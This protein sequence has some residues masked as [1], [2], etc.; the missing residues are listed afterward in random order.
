MS[1]I[2]LTNPP[3]TLVEAVALAQRLRVIADEAEVQLMRYL[4]WLEGRPDLWQ[5]AADATF[6]A[7]L[8]GTICRA[9][10]YRDSKLALEIFG[11]G[12]VEQAGLGASVVATR[13]PE[14][15]RDA[16]MV[17]LLAAREMNGVPPSKENAR[18]ILSNAHMLPKAE[19]SRAE[20]RLGAVAE[21][22]RANAELQRRLAEATAKLASAEKLVAKYKAQIDSMNA[23]ALGSKRKRGTEAPRA[24]A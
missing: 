14:E 3:A 19:A 2:W 13:V 20:Q 22:K 4:V 17:K 24:G 16:A 18:E 8:D 21:L 5:Q 12:R 15:K 1:D 23:P 7:F 10:R 11:P 6:D 9:D